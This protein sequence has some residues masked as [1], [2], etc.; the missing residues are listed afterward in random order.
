[1]DLG[2][3]LGLQAIPLA[4]LGHEVV[5]LDLGAELLARIDALLVP[6]VPGDWLNFP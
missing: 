1:M 2:C 4:E 5:A 6:A 3:G